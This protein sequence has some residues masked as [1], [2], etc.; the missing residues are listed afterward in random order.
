MARE[1]RITDV[2]QLLNVGPALATDVSLTL[3]FVDRKGESK[4]KRT[5]AF[6]ALAPGDTVTIM[7]GLMLPRDEAKKHMAPTGRELADTGLEL[8]ASWTWRD[9]RGRPLLPTLRARHS[10]TVVIDLQAYADTVAEGLI[11]QD[12][13]IQ[14]V[15]HDL[16]EDRRRE[17]FEDRAQR[18]FAD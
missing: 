7:P 16:R 6:P 13:T 17:R 11:V 3:A 10:D 8:H 12:S 4:E 18:S 9:N 1:G 5:L 14:S 15:L 2:A